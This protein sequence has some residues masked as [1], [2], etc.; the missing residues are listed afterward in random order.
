MLPVGVDREGD[1]E[2]CFEGRLE[3][4][5]QCGPLP[6]VLRAGD[7]PDARFARDG[8]RVIGRAVVHHDDCAG[9][10]P[11]GADHIGDDRRQRR[12]GIER[13]HHDAHARPRHRERCMLQRARLQSD[14]S[15]TVQHCGASDNRTILPMA[16]RY[17]H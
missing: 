14:K 16:P 7:E 15:L 3:T 5:D 6:L 9:V 8:G 10:T 17:C 11:E 13:R 4:T 2:A 12:S 1:G